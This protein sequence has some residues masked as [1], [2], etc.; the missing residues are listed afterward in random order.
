MY[1][2]HCI[3]TAGLVCGQNSMTF[4]FSVIL[5]S[6]LIILLFIF[7]CVG[8]CPH[9]LFCQSVEINQA[10]VVQSYNLFSKIYVHKHYVYIYKI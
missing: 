8:F 4:S 7:A 6:Y 10:A 3:P 5:F 9:G 2:S 1:L